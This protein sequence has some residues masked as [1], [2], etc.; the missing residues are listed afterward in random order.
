MGT[1]LVLGG[2]ACAV[3]SMVWPT[4]TIT[5]TPTP[6]QVAQGTEAQ[7]MAFWSWGRVADA[8]PGTTDPSI[9]FGS[10][11]GLLLLG[12]ALLAGVVAA[13][14]H[15]FRRG[16]DGLL[17]GAAGASWLAASLAAGVGQTAGRMQGYFGFTEGLTADTTAVGVFQLAAL[18]VLLG[19]LGAMVRRPALAFAGAVRA[20]GSALLGST[21]RR[22]STRGAGPALGADGTPAPPR[23]GTATIRDVE[24][25]AHPGWGGRA[26][27]TGSGSP[28][29]GGRS[30]VGFS[31]DA[32]DRSPAPVADPERF[33]PPR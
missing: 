17:V 16:S 28:R 11:W 6:D 30:G 27:G 12:V 23:V 9:D 26:V 19:G 4:N 13:A 33:R 2:V 7:R 15:A 8:S 21:R 20:R 5:F 25:G 18:V 3:P 22:T 10:P 14:S 31:D 1:L 24:P 32:Q 29:N